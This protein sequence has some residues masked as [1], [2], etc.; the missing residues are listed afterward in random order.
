MINNFKELQM[1]LELE[2][3]NYG[4]HVGFIYNIVKSENAL[5]WSFQKRLRITEYYLNTNK[6][7][8]Y[9]FS[10]YL[11][12]RKQLA[13]GFN[14]E[15]NVF[16]IGLRIMHIGPILTNS[17]VRVG[18]NCTLHINTALVAQGTND[19]VPTLGDN[20][21]IGIG[22]IILGDI[23]IADGIAV[24]ANAVV[25]KSF[26]EKDVAVAGVP[27]KIISDHGNSFW[28]GR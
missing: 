8:R 20:I 26:F 7:I 19:G 18:R 28:H 10:K 2:K 6:K 5:I 16:D 3:K 23:Y 14:I 9:L 17:R 21:V 24:G 15:T 11:L 22:A 13:F 4:S 25:N 27:A 12:H 1:T